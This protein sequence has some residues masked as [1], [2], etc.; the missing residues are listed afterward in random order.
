[1]PGKRRG[2][3]LCLLL[4]GRQL[5][6]GGALLLLLP[7]LLNLPRGGSHKQAKSIGVAYRFSIVFSLLGLAYGFL[8]KV[9]DFG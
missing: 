2:A 9:L 3:E 1:L 6:G 4:D 5:L 7:L 8:S